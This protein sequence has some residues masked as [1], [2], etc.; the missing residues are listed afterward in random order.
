VTH[1]RRGGALRR[2]RLPSCRESPRDARPAWRPPLH[3]D[4][5]DQLLFWVAVGWVDV[6]RIELRELGGSTSIPPAR[7]R[8]R[9]GCAPRR[10]HAPPK[11]RGHLARLSELSGGEPRLVLATGSSARASTIGG[12][13]PCCSRCR[14]PGEGHRRPVRRP[15]ST[16]RPGKSAARIYDYVNAK[17]PVLRRM[18]PACE[19]LPRDELHGRT[20]PDHGRVPPGC[21][22]SGGRALKPRAIQAR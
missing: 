6:A 15:G 18:F 8:P 9:L 7:A 11:A 14:L 13:T 22:R 17:V 4:Q 12:S 19:D 16:A 21:Q 2:R 10:R 1:R 5:D 3:A 20:P